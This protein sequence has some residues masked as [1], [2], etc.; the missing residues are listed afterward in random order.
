MLVLNSTTL[1]LGIGINPGTGLTA[2]DVYATY[3]DID[4]TSPNA[5]ITPGQQITSASTD[6]TTVVSAPASGTSRQIKYLSIFNRDNTAQTITIYLDTG[7]A[8][9]GPTDYT[10]AFDTNSGSNTVS[11]GAYD[12]LTDLSGNGRHF[13]QVTGGSRPLQVSDGGVNVADFTG[14]LFMTAAADYLQFVAASGWTFLAETKPTAV[15]G[16]NQTIQMNQNNALASS[17]EDGAF[18]GVGYRKNTESGRIEVG[19]G[20]VQSTTFFKTYIWRQDKTISLNTWNTVAAAFSGTQLDLQFNNEVSYFSPLMGGNAPIATAG[21]MALGRSGSTG[22]FFTGRM[23]RIRFFN[24]KL[25]KDEINNTLAEWKGFN[26]VRNIFSAIL[27]PNEMLQYSDAEGWAIID[28]AGNRKTKPLSMVSNARYFE[29]PPSVAQTAV[30]Q[31]SF[32]FQRMVMPTVSFSPDV[33]MVGLAMSHSTAALASISLNLGIYQF[34]SQSLL[35]KSSA[36]RTIGIYGT[37]DAHSSATDA[38]GTRYWSIPI[39]GWTISS[40]E[41]IIGWMF[42]VSTSLTSGSYSFFVNR[43][44]ISINGSEFGGGTG[45]YTSP[46][47]WGIYSAT[48]AL[49]PRMFAWSEVVQTGANI[50]TPWIALGKT[51]VTTV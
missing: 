16:T 24:R 22:Q 35:L 30:A 42:S 7:T 15:P 19:I 49:L 37:A 36:L 3:V 20:V 10:A 31:G 28:R 41:Y 25:T 11:T 33:A 48:T 34:S 23:R 40:G 46:L 38:S 44:S 14:A 17:T 32:Y 43:T 2:M 39:N 47:M 12:Q 1:S 50:G 27:Q 45:N 9:A 51:N 26:V 21:T 18:S 4:S 6:H 29:F 8:A 5:I 13:T